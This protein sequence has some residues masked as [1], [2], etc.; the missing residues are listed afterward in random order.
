MAV[1]DSEITAGTVIRNLT[2]GGDVVSDHPTNPAGRPTRIIAG[3]DPQG[4]V[5]AGG[6]ID[7]F[8]IVGKLLDAVVAASVQP[9]GGTVS[10]QARARQ[11]RMTLA[12]RPSTSR[13]ESL[14]WVLLA[15][16]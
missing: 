14:K 1:F 3:V 8:Q 6:I 7:N 10:S 13:L 12:I 5:T 11:L 2:I 4:Y 15:T 16:R 9:Y